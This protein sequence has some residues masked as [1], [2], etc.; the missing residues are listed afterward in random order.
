MRCRKCYKLEHTHIEEYH[1]TVDHEASTLVK[2]V[3]EK[4]V[5]KTKLSV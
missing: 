5:E 3:Y 1:Y 4:T 2:V